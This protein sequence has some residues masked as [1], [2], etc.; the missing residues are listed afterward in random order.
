[1]ASP[2]A[3]SLN[4]ALGALAA[5]GSCISYALWLIIQAKMSEKYPCQYTSTAL[6]S[7]MG[8]IQSVIYALCTEKDWSQWKLGWNIKLLTVAYAGI[9]ASGMMYMIISWCV[10]MRG[11]LYVSVFNPLLL[12]MV[13]L[14]G[15][16]FLEEKLYLGSILGALLIVLGLYFV[17]WGKGKEM[18]KMAQL[19]PSTSP[20]QI[21]PIEI[22]VDSFKELEGKE[23][24]NGKSY[25]VE[26]DQDSASI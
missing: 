17:L 24:H 22:K 19:M 20:P 15:A 12:V 4:R 2:H 14:A 7:I 10:R 13:A 23:S 9:L 5:L 3:A 18:K 6:M 21:E 25:H 1:M 8:A 26:E 11:P 16:I